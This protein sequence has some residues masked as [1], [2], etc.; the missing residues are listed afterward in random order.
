[1]TRGTP[2]YES[3]NIVV[4]GKEYA[5]HDAFP[6]KKLAKETAKDARTYGLGPKGTR[7]RAVYRDMGKNAGRLRHAIFTRIEKQPKRRRRR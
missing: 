3:G 5:I 4:D 7:T 2:A 1:M 6:G